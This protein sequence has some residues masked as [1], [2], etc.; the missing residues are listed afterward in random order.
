M[1]TVSK[2]AV[3]YNEQSIHVFYS[4][5]Q[6]TAY[7]WNKLEQIDYFVQNEYLWG[8]VN[9]DVKKEIEKFGLYN[10]INFS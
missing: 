5:G 3:N 10:I 7:D 9:W 2:F 1:A 4:D 6:I 8:K